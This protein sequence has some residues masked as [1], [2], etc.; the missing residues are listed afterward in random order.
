MKKKLWFLALTFGLLP[1]LVSAKGSASI[2]G[3]STVENGGKV[4]ISVTLKNV[5]SWNIEI[6]SSGSTSGCSDH[7][8]SDVTGNGKNAT[9]TFSVTCKATSEGIIGFTVTGDITS[10]DGDSTEVDLSKRVTVTKPRE[11]AT[12]ASLAS[13]SIDGYTLTPEFNKETLEYTV[14]VP[15]TVDKI[16]L[17]A[18][19]NESHASLEGTGEFEVT[20]G[21]NT[22]EVVC[23]AENGTKKT[24]VVTV[25]VQDTNPVEVKIGD[26]AYTLIKNSK[27][28]TKPENYEETTVTIDGF[29]IPAFHSE[30]TDFTLVGLK[31][32]IGQ[33]NLAIYNNNTYILYNE[34]KATVLNLYLTDFETELNGYMK[35]TLMINDTEVPVYKYSEDSRYVICYGMNLTTGKYEYYNYDTKEGTFQIWNKEEIE[36]ANEQIKT[37]QYICISFG[38]GLFFAFLLILHLLKKKRKSKKEE[39]HK[40][41]ERS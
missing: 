7:P 28:L 24:Y 9:K 33:I 41:F 23:T 15:S 29:T 12:D 19:V 6:K 8:F 20:E 4:T 30:I 34:I 31:N 17:D 1:T 40:E 25:N 22:F 21:V 38:I 13:L 14:T 37:Y 39:Q 10:E 3:P 35:S 5:A 11:K 16:K 36:R 32:E 18:K 2:S 27:N 26:N